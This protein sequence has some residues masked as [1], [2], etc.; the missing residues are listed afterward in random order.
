[1][2]V[3]FCSNRGFLI[4]CAENIDAIA[5]ADS[6]RAV[7]GATVEQLCA[8]TPLLIVLRLFTRPPAPQFS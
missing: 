1:M 3:P 8:A 2:F 7:F 5:A 4:E 6:I